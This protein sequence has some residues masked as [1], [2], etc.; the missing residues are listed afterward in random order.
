MTSLKDMSINELWDKVVGERMQ[1]HKESNVSNNMEEFFRR[2]DEFWKQVEEGT[3][4][5]SEAEIE[6]AKR[7]VK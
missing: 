3:L 7:L 4:E 2:M 6:F 5:F 1:E